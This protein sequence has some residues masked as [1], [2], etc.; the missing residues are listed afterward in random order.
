MNK[1]ASVSSKP[2]SRSQAAGSRSGTKDKAVSRHPEREFLNGDFTELINQS[3]RQ[4]TQAKLKEKLNDPVQRKTPVIQRQWVNG[5]DKNIRNK[6]FSK[7]MDDNSSDEKTE[8]ISG[9]WYEKLGDNSYGNQA[10]SEQD[11]EQ[12]KNTGTLESQLRP[13]SNE[14]LKVNVNPW[15]IELKLKDGSVETAQQDNM[16]QAMNEVKKIWKDKGNVELNVNGPISYTISLTKSLDGYGTKEDFQDEI[17]MHMN[18]AVNDKI[19]TD[20]KSGKNSVQ[21]VFITTYSKWGHTYLTEEGGFDG[22]VCFVTTERSGVGT[23]D[24]LKRS[25]QGNLVYPA[26]YGLEDAGVAIDMAHEIGHTFG[27]AHRDKDPSLRGGLMYDILYNK[28]NSGQTILRGIDLSD[29]EKSE[30]GFAIGQGTMWVPKLREIIHKKSKL[31]RQNSDNAIRDT[32]DWNEED[33]KKA[34]L[35]TE[36][37]RDFWQD[38]IKNRPKFTLAN[39]ISDA[40]NNKN[41][42]N[43]KNKK[44]RKP[45]AKAK[46]IKDEKP[47]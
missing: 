32:Y 2:E 27:L 20:K 25:N 46:P 37:S 35:A 8:R 9:S 39:S 19:D 11:L 31:K 16:N 22:P 13:D 23:E 28:E 47:E 41:N 36:E 38:S 18:K 10:Y 40:A 45:R 7:W 3:P 30:A 15:L 43:K 44:M 29:D 24:N 5:Q 4:V 34:K 42:K 1:L 12:F 17:N 21:A 14:T 6:T 26:G 33:E